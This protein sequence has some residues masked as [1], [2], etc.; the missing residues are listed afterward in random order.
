MSIVK[1]HMQKYNETKPQDLFNYDIRVTRCSLKIL[2]DDT[3]C[4]PMNFG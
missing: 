4:W 2:E 1:I 3:G